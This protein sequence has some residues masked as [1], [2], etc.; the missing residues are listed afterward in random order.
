MPLTWAQ[1]GGNVVERTVHAEGG[2]FPS[3][4][5]TSALLQDIWKF[6]GNSDK[7]NTSL[8]NTGTKSKA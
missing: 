8:F 2:H 4:T 1:R 7:S 6:F 3:V 5:N